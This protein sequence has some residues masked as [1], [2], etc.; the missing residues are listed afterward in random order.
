MKAI[1]IREPWACLIVHGPKRIENRSRNIV[2]T[3]RGPVLIH[4]SKSYCEDDLIDAMMFNDRRH[5][6]PPG[7]DLLSCARF[8]AAQRGGVIGI[9]EITDVVTASD[10]PWFTGPV[11]IVLAN[12]RPLE[13]YPQNGRLGLFDCFYPG[14]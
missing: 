8:D 3:Y 14:L 5:L 13:F 10:D 1:S 7:S 9:A 6:L 4:V 11:G 2:G 12:V